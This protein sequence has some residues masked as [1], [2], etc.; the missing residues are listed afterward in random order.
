MTG[1]SYYRRKERK[2]A[3]GYILLSASQL[4]EPCH[5]GITIEQLAKSKT[6]TIVYQMRSNLAGLCHTSPPY[7]LPSFVRRLIA[8]ALTVRDIQVLKPDSIV[9]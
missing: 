6:R 4:D 1:I 5:N 7:S 3:F 9:N 2:D 8:D